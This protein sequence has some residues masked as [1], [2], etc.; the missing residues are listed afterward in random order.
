MDEAIHGRDS[1]AIH[2]DV[3]VIGA[4]FAGL[5]AVHKARN[6]LGLTVQGFENGSDIG[7]TWFW[8]RYPG[9]RADTEVTAYCY[10]FDR[11]LFDQWKWS[12]RYPR[13]AEILSY[14]DMFANRYDLRRSYLFDTQV[15]KVRFDEAT[16]RWDLI[17]DTGQRYSAQ[18][19]VEGV[20]LLSSTNIPDFPGQDSFPG[21]LY[22]TSRWPQQPIDFAGKR[23]GVIGT[24]S[25]GVQVISEIGSQAA[26]L[27]VFQRTPQYIVPAQHGPLDPD[28]LNRISADY[29]GYWQSVL[30]SVTAFGFDESQTP[31]EGMSDEERDAIFEKQWNSGGG[32]QFMFATFNDIVTSVEANDAATDFIRRKIAQIVDDPETAAK[33]TPTDYYAKRPICCDDY[34]ETYNRENVSLVDAKAHPILE[35]TPKGIRTDEG[36]YELDVIVF[37]T[38]F[39]AV[40]G[41]YLK[42]DHI[43]RGGMSLRDKWADRPRVHLGLMST[44]FP[45]IFMIFGPMG[46]FTNQPPAHEAQVDWVARAIQFVREHELSTI[47]P[48]QESEDQWLA[49]CDEI[50]N[51]TLI[52][53]VDSWIN[54]AN[55]P[56]KPIAIMFYM[57]GMGAY[58]E[59]LQHAIDS[60][61]TGF[62]LDG[63]PVRS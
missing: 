53:K 43:G 21:E 50:A 48:T 1:E 7:G 35:I 31:G 25:S 32:F 27:T 10:S 61:Y 4:G 6:D 54:G 19:V 52:P 26:H 38:G 29:E 63:Q 12:Q 15:E 44:D 51:A 60:D 16:D 33:L 3:A 17:L 47:E 62:R 5:Y 20:G 18:F 41:N 8:N 24:G 13:Q 55:I 59:Q 45:N 23:V 22:H 11:E 49:T 9:A 30:A 46:P 14:L 37:A 57:A 58:M 36:E 34:Y 28:L 39:D 2:V 40:T 42:I 56:G